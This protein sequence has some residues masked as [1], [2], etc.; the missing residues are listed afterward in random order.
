MAHW[1]C[2]DVEGQMEASEA[3]ILTLWPKE[4]WKKKTIPQEKWQRLISHVDPKDAGCDVSLYT[5]TWLGYRAQLLGQTLVH[6]L[7]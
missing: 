1:S 6:M 2:P 4:Q 7:L 3:A 5:S